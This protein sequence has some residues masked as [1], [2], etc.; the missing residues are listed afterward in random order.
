MWRP[1]REVVWLVGNGVALQLPLVLRGK[2]PRHRVAEDLSIGVNG[3][4]GI[5]IDPKTAELKEVEGMRYLV[6][7]TAHPSCVA[8]IRR[9]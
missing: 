5:L 2:S 1:Q 3:Q 4:R 9:S 6:A 8:R 7:L